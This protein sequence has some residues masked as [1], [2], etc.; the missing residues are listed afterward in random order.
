MYYERSEVLPVVILKITVS[1]DVL[2]CSLRDYR[3]YE[4]QAASQFFYSKDGGKCSSRISITIY[5][6]T[7]HFISKDSNLQKENSK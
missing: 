7:Q 1:L 4:E 6:M 3:C 5:H 2:P